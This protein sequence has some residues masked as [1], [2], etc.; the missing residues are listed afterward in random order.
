MC[1]YQEI[2]LGVGLPLVL[3]EVSFLLWTPGTL[4]HK[5]LGSSHLTVR[6]LRFQ[7]R[8]TR[9]TFYMH[10]GD[11]NSG[12]HTWAGST[13]SPEMPPQLKLGKLERL[14]HEQGCTCK[15]H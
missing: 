15:S 14:I 5:P 7:T 3:L 10:S 9:S 13:L 11:L 2:M 12:P 6:G 1:G 4:T 8:I